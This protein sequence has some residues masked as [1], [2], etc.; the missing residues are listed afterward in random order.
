MICVTTDYI[1]EFPETPVAHPF[2][3]HFKS[4]V[5]KVKC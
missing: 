1:I 5:G 4:S 3:I 2:A